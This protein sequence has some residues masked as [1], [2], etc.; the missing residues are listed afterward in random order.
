MNSTIKKK[1]EKIEEL[2]SLRGLAAILVVFFHLPK[3]NLI[4]DIGFINNGYLMVD[5]FFV[6]SGFVI[7]NAYEN[8]I[9]GTKD[10][11]RFQFLR[12]GRLYPVHIVF[13]SV[14]VLIEIAKYLASEKLGISLNS[15][16]FETNNLSALIK[17]I[18]LVSAVL[19][20]QALTYNFPA[21]SIS[22]EFY[23]YLVFAFSILVTRKNTTLFTF[24]AVI[25]LLMLIT[26][27]TFGFESLL[28]CF[29]GFFIGCLTA[30]FTKKRRPNLPNLFSLLVFLVI[31]FFLHFKT[32][33][34][35]DWLIYL[36]TAALITSL[37]LSP[38]GFL[39]RILKFNFI[40][41]PLREKSRD[42]AFRKLT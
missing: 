9:T 14:F 19:P 27:T 29:S 7:F 40:E 41:K 26:E 35:F 21:W 16:P 25:S 3:W 30:K 5:L 12:F 20:N 28:R 37:V 33:K 2:E 31:V 34:D 10:L 6:L 32:S 13:L 23:T 39:N 11:L 22:V 4:L 24:F 8:K 1:A 15:M 42:Y 18:F 36:L 38:K 17:N